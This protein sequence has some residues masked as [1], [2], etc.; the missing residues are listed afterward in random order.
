MM[1]F[2]AKQVSFCVVLSDCGS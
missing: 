2:E 1:A